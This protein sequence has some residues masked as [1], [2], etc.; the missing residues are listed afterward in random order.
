ML[1]DNTMCD[2]W[3]TFFVEHRLGQQFQIAGKR[4]RDRQLQSLWRRL[5]LAVP[6][7]MADMKFEPSLLHGELHIAN[8]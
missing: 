3:P 7:L 4:Y 2:D 5:K 8:T 1:L 6:K